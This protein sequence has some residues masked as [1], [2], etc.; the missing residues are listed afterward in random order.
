MPSM[1]RVNLECSGGVRK[2]L[3]V[4]L[5]VGQLQLGDISTRDGER[6]CIPALCD[7]NH[8]DRTCR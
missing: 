8:C 2:A 6:Q 3:L 1:L 7:G 5:V 4:V